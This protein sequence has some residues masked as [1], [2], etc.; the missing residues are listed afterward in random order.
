M[1]TQS[2]YTNNLKQ[3]LFMFKDFIHQVSIIFN[4][5]RFITSLA[6]HLHGIGNMLLLGHTGGVHGGASGHRSGLA[7][8]GGVHGHSMRWSK[9]SGGA[10]C[11][12]RCQQSRR[13]CCKVRCSSIETLKLR[14]YKISINSSNNTSCLPGSQCQLILSPH[15][16][17]FSPSDTTCFEPWPDADA[18]VL[19]GCQCLQEQSQRDQWMVVAEELRETFEHFSAEGGNH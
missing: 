6:R 13:V 16:S 2:S 1:P 3:N 11:W 18:K 15:C 4:S 5:N 7:S 19:A 9:A 8:L 12:K 10:P 17:Q 14:F